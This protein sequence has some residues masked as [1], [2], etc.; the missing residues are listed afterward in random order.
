MTTTPQLRVLFFDVFGTCV[1]QRK[2]VADELWKAAQEALESDV[3]SISSK[4]RT[5]AKEM[6]YE[7]W[8]EFGAEQEWNKEGEKF[9]RGS[10]AEQS[11]VDWKAVDKNRI[12]LLPKLLAH[13]GL[14]IPRE[15]ASTS[16]FQVGEGSLWDASQLEHLGLVWHRLT[17]WPDT[18]RGLDLL[19]RKFSTVTLSNTYNE[20]LQHLV[21]RSS[22]P[23]THVYSADMFQSFKP[24]PKVY[25]GAAEKMGVKP[26]ECA[27]VAA[28]LGDL[29]GAKACGFYT[30][31]VD[32]PLEEKNPELREEN[33]PGMVIKQDEDGFVA[34]AERLGI[35]VG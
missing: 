15:D 17:P 20:L 30:I 10:I 8:F 7:Q 25:L 18:C 35:Q 27:L 11:A 28:H 14:I 13:R 29:K 3:S 26:E 2:P 32:R 23:F 5:K 1:A 12:E 31:Y 19:N 34:L 22:I 4:V 9:V 24:N 6:S 16:E 33:I 21:A